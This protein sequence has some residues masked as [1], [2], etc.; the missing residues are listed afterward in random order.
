MFALALFAA[1]WLDDVQ[2]FSTNVT[3]TGK[4]AASAAAVVFVIVGY[5]ARRTL[6]AVFAAIIVGGV[7]L[8]AVNH[9]D[10]LQ[11]KTEDTFITAPAASEHGLAPFAANGS[12]VTVRGAGA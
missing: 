5:I 10:D 6:G 11:K 7:V 4:V 9:T 8:Y 1:S 12:T 2:T 3:A